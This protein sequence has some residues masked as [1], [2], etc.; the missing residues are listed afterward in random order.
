MESCCFPP[1]YVQCSKPFSRSA[2]II[3]LREDLV[4]TLDELDI[5][6]VLSGHDH[7]YVR[8][9]QMKNLQPLEESN[10]RE[11]GSVINPDGTLYL[12]ANSSSGSKYY[13]LKDPEFYSAE[14]ITI[15]STNIYEYRSNT[16]EFRIYDIPCRYNG[17][18]RYL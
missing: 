4:P 11:D 15:K 5:D 7:S 17:S 10:G 14:Q 8:T 6:A 2:S 1:F 12:T 9:Y 3:K 16:N 13:N 18:N